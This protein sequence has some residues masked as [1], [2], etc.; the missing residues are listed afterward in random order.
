[1]SLKLNLVLAYLPMNY[2]HEMY[3]DA[4]LYKLKQNL[5][6]DNILILM[7]QLVPLDLT[8]YKYIIS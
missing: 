2:A 1:M 4:I 6:W 5:R 3:L 8:D 7:P